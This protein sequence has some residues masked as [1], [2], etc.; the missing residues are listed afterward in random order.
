M[1]YNMQQYREMRSMNPW[2]IWMNMWLAS[3]SIFLPTVKINAKIYA[4]RPEI[5]KQLQGLNNEN[6]NM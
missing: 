3:W 1:I 6:K 4:I 2:L 5:L